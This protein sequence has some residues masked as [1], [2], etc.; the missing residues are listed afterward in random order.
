VGDLNNPLSPMDR[1]WKQ[2]LNIDTWTLT[3]VI[4]FFKKDLTGIDRTI[5]PKT[6]VYTFH[7]APYGTSSKPDHIIGQKTG[8]HIYKNIKNIPCILSD[9]HGLRLIFNNSINNRKP[10][11][12]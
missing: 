5:Y 1:I 7:S 2:R 6:K 11:F 9:H 12:M 3:E 10:T 8:L 4:F